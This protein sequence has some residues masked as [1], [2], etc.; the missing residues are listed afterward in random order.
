M[1]NP[2]WPYKYKLCK[3]TWA[4]NLGSWFRQPLT[5]SW[6]FPVSKT[7]FTIATLKPIVRLLVSSQYVLRQPFSSKRNRKLNL[8]S[9]FILSSIY[10][11]NVNVAEQ[12]PEKII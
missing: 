4:R 5:L 9:S 1:R 12:I 8:F 11:N 6:C 7:Q 3:Y 2:Y 10:S